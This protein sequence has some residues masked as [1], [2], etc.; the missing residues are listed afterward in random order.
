MSNPAESNTLTYSFYGYRL[1]AR[2]TYFITIAA[3]S[4]LAGLARVRYFSYVPAD[5]LYINDEVSYVLRLISFTRP[6]IEDTVSLGGMNG[7]LG[8]FYWILLGGHDL[9][10]A[11]D[12]KTITHILRS[13]NIVIACLAPTLAYILMLALRVRA[14]AA[15]AAGFVVLSFPLYW[16]FSQYVWTEIP[17]SLF[18][19]I[20]AFLVIKLS[21]LSTRDVLSV[22]TV[23]ALLVF[24]ADTF[25]IATTKSIGLFVVVLSSILVVTF[26]SLLSSALY[27]AAL[28]VAVSLAKMSGLITDYGQDI[29]SLLLSSIGTKLFWIYLIC[30][31]IASI[32]FILFFIAAWITRPIVD[33]AGWRRPTQVSGDERWYRSGSA[34]YA[35]LTFC[36]VGGPVVMGCLFYSSADH[37]LTHFRGASPFI[38]SLVMLSILLFVRP[39]QDSSPNPASVGSRRFFYWMIAATTVLAFLVSPIVIIQ[40]GIALVGGFRIQPFDWMLLTP[41]QHLVAGFPTSSWDFRIAIVILY[42]A[43]VLSIFIPGNLPKA[44]LVSIVGMTFN[45]HYATSLWASSEAGRYSA[46][47]EMADYLTAEAKADPNARI[48]FLAGDQGWDVWWGGFQF[49]YVWQFP[50][51]TRFNYFLNSELALTDN[52]YVVSLRP[53]LNLDSTHITGGTRDSVHVVRI[54]TANKHYR[55]AA[56]SIARVIETNTKGFVGKPQTD[57]ASVAY[58][59]QDAS[60]FPVFLGAGIAHR[61]TLSVAPTPDA[62]PPDCKVTLSNGPTIPLTVQSGTSSNQITLSAMISSPTSRMVALK[63][64]C[65]K[66]FDDPVRGKFILPAISM[67]VSKS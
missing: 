7:G 56:V 41:F 51:R 8:L 20:H 53:V 32:G 61:L 48:V 57:G 31:I 39:N 9:T 5:T 50:E 42:L 64:N 11:Y 55:N 62:G 63:F 24:F 30:G 29:K 1:S 22:G 14:D 10:A 58:M 44:A 45:I 46:H 37:L 23:V 49:P 40:N 65:A 15:A 25:L 3:L 43:A 26:R 4:I 12:F 27:L 17:M 2:T 67:S 38:P 19:M 59:G 28:A 16:L 54:A 66:T 52:D 47:V 21:R 36:Y 33:L 60:I 34:V 6:H 18:I 35:G 13:L